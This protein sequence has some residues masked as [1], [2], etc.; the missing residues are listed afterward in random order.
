MA[1]LDMRE[2]ERERE[3]ERDVSLY[4]D[5]RKEGSKQEEYTGY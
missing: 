2:R 4:T 5:G 1:C 3:R